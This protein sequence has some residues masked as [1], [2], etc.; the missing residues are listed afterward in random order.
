[1]AVTSLMG[2][3]HGFGFSFVL[4]EV[5]GLS[6]SNLAVSLLS[7]NVGVEVGQLAIILLVWPALRLLDAWSPRTSG[8]ARA[9]VAC[10]SI[11]VAAVWVVTRSAALLHAV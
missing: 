3:L 5:L 2:L 4:A 9:G 11:A 6:S 10:A 7:Y 8:Y 1:M